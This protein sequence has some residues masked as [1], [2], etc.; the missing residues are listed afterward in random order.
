MSVLLFIL[1]GEDLL[2]ESVELTLDLRDGETLRVLV[3]LSFDFVSISPFRFGVGD[4]LQVI[5][6]FK[7]FTLFLSTLDVVVK[8]VSCRLLLG[9]FSV[10]R[11][12][13]VEINRNVLLFL[14]ERRLGGEGGTGGGFGMDDTVT[15][16]GAL[17]LY[18]ANT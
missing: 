7:Y 5:L 15:D 13:I 1:F 17:L 14:D 9:D 4:S 16:E 2:V 11:T 18:S 8:Q 6:S 10:V 3:T 12:F